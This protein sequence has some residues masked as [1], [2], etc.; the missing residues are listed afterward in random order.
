MF[1]W[2]GDKRGC[3]VQLSLQIQ[4]LDKT[5]LTIANFNDYLKCIE[6]LAID[7]LLLISLLNRFLIYFELP[8]VFCALYPSYKSN[9][10]NVSFKIP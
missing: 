1:V 10:L 2:V 3:V 5:V 8:E 6:S 4:V 7:K 9:K